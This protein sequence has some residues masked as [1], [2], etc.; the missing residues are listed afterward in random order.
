MERTGTSVKTEI[1]T[2]EELG[3]HREV[4]QETPRAQ[5]NYAVWEL[6]TVGK[7][8]DLQR[9]LRP[10]QL[11]KLAW[12]MLLQDT[13]IA[14]VEFIDDETSPKTMAQIMS[15]SPPVIPTR[16][17]QG[18]LAKTTITS[19]EIIQI[20][21]ESMLLWGSSGGAIKQ[22]F[23]PLLERVSNAMAL[24]EKF[25]IQAF[26]DLHTIDV[27]TFQGILH[28]LNCYG[29]VMKMNDQQRAMRQK[30]VQGSGIGSFVGK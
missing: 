22:E 6:P 3:V 14:E 11:E 18:L 16:L 8:W 25:G 12:E 15:F 23:H 4:E 30:A 1:W 17:V 20:D 21:R 9:R 5:Y 10:W 19:R 2:V 7:W 29:Q 27:R 13:S 28:C 24:Y 26:G